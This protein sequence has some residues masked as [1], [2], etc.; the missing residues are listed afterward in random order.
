M[1]QALEFLKNLAEQLQTQ[2]NVCTASPNYCIQEHRMVFG[3]NED[4]GGTI[5]WFE[6]DSSGHEPAEGRKEKALDRYYNR[7]DK[8]PDGWTRCGYKREWQHTGISFLTHEAAHA[9]VKSQNHRHTYEIRVYVESHYRNREMREVRRLLAG[10]VQACLDSLR[11][12][13][14][15]CKACEADDSKSIVDELTAD[16]ENRAIA[17]LAALD[18]AKEPHQ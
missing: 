13:L 9:Y 18:T 7:Y 12:V 15:A 8:E 5:G 16:I 14:D 1:S 2:D 3:T 6:D 17:A 4:Y 10:P 11:E